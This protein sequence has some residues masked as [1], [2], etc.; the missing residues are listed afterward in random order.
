MEQR[1]D[2]RRVTYPRM[3][4]LPLDSTGA[5]KMTRSS[6]ESVGCHEVYIDNT[7]KTIHG[8]HMDTDAAASDATNNGGGGEA[9]SGVT[10]AK[11]S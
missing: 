7:Q 1:A 5:V 2:A 10:G 6:L 8:K 11:A 3:R 4:G 9:T